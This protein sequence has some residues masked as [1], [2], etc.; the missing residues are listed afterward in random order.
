MDS[1]LE[2]GASMSPVFNY[3]YNNTVS[4][5]TAGLILD[6]RIGILAPGVGATY[7]VTLTLTQDIVDNHQTLVN[8]VTATGAFT[9]PAGVTLQASSTSDDPSTAAVDDPTIINLTVTP[10]IEITKTASVTDVDSSGGVSIGDKITYTITISNTGETPLNNINIT[11]TLWIRYW[12]LKS[13]NFL[14]SCIVITRV[15]L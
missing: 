9:T 12:H 8:T 4:A 2:E 6:P 1:K 11:D 10:S 14:D 7:Q 15:C 3:T 13:F 5:T